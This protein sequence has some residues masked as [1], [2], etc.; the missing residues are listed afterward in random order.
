MS[1]PFGLNTWFYD[2]WK[3]D[4]RDITRWLVHSAIFEPNDSSVS[5]L[6][7]RRIVGWDES[8]P[9]DWISAPGKGRVSCSFSEIRGASPEEV[10]PNDIIDHAACHSIEVR[11]TCPPVRHWNGGLASDD[12]GV[13]VGSSIYEFWA[14]SSEY[15]AAVK[16][17]NSLDSH[18]MRAVLAGGNA[19]ITRGYLA[20]SVVIVPRLAPFLLDIH[21][22][23]APKELEP[24]DQVHLISET[25]DGNV[26]LD[27]DVGELTLE[28]GRELGSQETLQYLRIYFTGCTFDSLHGAPTDGVPDHIALYP[29]NRHGCSGSDWRLTLI[30]SGTL[31]STVEVGLIR[32]IGVGYFSSE[33]W[34]DRV[35]QHGFSAPARVIHISPKDDEAAQSAREMVSAVGRPANLCDPFVDAE[36]L[37]ALSAVLGGGKVLGKK[38]SLNSVGQSWF[39]RHATSARSHGRLHDR[40][41]VGTR[42]ALL[43]GTSLNGIGKRHCFVVQ[44]D[45]LMRSQAQSVFDALWQ[46]A[47]ACW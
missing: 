1:Q 31:C 41:I 33:P 17:W 36:S 4:R 45:N 6:L 32:G 30:A 5:Q 9:P 3:P 40:F 13:R 14:Q 2:A 22:V 19:A 11:R 29:G 7:F 15:E 28:P 8:P 27:H 24:W 37:N 20:S 42:G 46:E 10:L 25:L 21:T 12:F 44:L 39:T 47:E 18:E 34:V 38:K 26:P 16:I 35:P 23:V 43:I